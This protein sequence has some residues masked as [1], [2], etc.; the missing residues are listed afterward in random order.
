MAYTEINIKRFK[1]LSNIILDIK[2][3][4][5]HKECEIKVLRSL[6]LN[7]N[8]YNQLPYEY[9]NMLLEAIFKDN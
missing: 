6:V 3:L 9:K 4:N 8:T 2:K 7:S 1:K 5:L